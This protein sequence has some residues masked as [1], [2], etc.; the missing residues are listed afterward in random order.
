MGER[1]SFGPY[2]VDET[3]TSIMASVSGFEPVQ[4][5]HIRQSELCATCHTLYTPYLDASGQVAGEFPEQTPYLEW[6]NSAYAGNLGCNDCHMPL[7]PGNVQLAITGGPAAE[8][9]SPA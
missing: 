6:L 9:R 7:I 3:N 2:E 1:A 8:R 5:E 4:A